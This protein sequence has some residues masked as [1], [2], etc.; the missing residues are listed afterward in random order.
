MKRQL[1]HFFVDPG[2]ISDHLVTFSKPV[3]HQISQVLRLNLQRDDVIILDG[4][5]RA[6]LAKLNGKVDKNVTAVIMEKLPD[7]NEEL[8]DLTLCFS[9]TKREKLEWILQKCTEIGVSK[10]QPFVS[11]RSVSRSETVD[12]NRTARWE[13]IIREA[14]E[15]SERRKLPALL[16]VLGF[17]DLLSGPFAD[18]QRLMAYEASDINQRL[19]N[20]QLLSIPTVLLIGPEGGFTEVE[21]EKAI[22]AGFKAFSLGKR[23]L[24]METACI[25]A[26]SLVIDRLETKSEGYD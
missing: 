1:Q 5:G 24:R 8:I 7:E 25:V 12:E 14:A 11:E 16:G 2:S 19:R 17:N 21:A 10:F 6:F 23:I 9:L 26:S 18:A 4:T 15:Q 22:S 13:S 20:S 3:S